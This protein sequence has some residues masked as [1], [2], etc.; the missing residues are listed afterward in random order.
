DA[1]EYGLRGKPVVNP[2]LHWDPETTTTD[3]GTTT[4]NWADIPWTKHNEPK[5]TD[6]YDVR[7]GMYLLGYQLNLMG[8]LPHDVALVPR[9]IT[10]AVRDTILDTGPLKEIRARI[11]P[12]SSKA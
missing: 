6:A 10:Q 2:K 7:R 12:E 4:L 8:A 5:K 11:N 3:G 9:L 1:I